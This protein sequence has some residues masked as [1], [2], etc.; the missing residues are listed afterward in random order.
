MRVSRILSVLSATLLLGLAAPAVPASATGSGSLGLHG[1]VNGRWRLDPGSGA[2]AGQRY[3]LYRGYGITSLGVTGASGRSGSL[4]FVRSA[5][6]AL[7]MHVWINS[8]SGTVS[9][10][11]SS[12]DEFPG[13]ASCKGYN[14]RWHST[15]T[16]GAYAG[17]S[18]SGTG[19][20]AM[21][22]PAQA[23]G[24]GTFR[25]YFH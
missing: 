22:A 9:V 18:G 10:Q 3:Q 15:K 12:L 6:C 24:V 7:G 2:D 13:G 8:P 14:F 11:I 23:G 17:R 4:G 25:V 21:H 16:T 1:I 5:N 19:S 20:F